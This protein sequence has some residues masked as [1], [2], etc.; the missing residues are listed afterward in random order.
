[1]SS[2]PAVTPSPATDTDTPLVPWMLS[3]L[4]PHRGRVTLLA[5]LLLLEI[6]L[7]ALQPW[8]LAIVI[9]NVLGGAGCPGGRSR[10]SP[11]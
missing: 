1:M 3:F 8:P 6:G 10:L 7:G 5:V 9:D 4:R 11:R 2:T